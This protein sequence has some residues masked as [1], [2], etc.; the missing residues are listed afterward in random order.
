MSHNER[1]ARLEEQMKTIF[2]KQDATDS[3]LSRV[4]KEIGDLTTLTA[5]QADTIALLAKCVFG[6]VALVIL[7]VG[8]AMVN[9]VVHDRSGQVASQPA[10]MFE[11]AGASAVK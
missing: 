6:A 5:R 8:G 4:A 1:V 10:A 2:H 11:A 7:A 9:L 3:T